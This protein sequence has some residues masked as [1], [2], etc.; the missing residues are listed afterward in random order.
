[1]I[2]TIHQKYNED[3]TKL[4]TPPKTQIW[5]IF[6]VFSFPELLCRHWLYWLMIL[7]FNG[8]IKTRNICLLHTTYINTPNID[9]IIYRVVAVFAP[10]WYRVE[11]TE[12]RMRALF[13]GT[14]GFVMLALTCSFTCLLPQNNIGYVSVMCFPA[15]CM[16]YGYSIYHYGMASFSGFFASFMS[17]LANE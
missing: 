4:F 13:L 6:Y 9:F 2:L 11:M 16:T 10:Q 17:L 5:E 12:P 8:F 3:N 15:Q 1:M 7:W 14:L